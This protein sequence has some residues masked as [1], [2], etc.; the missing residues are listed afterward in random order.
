MYRVCKAFKFDALRQWGAGENNMNKQK[1]DAAPHCTEQQLVGNISEAQEIIEAFAFTD[2]GNTIG[3]VSCDLKTH[4]DYPHSW[5]VDA[6]KAWL[7]ANDSLHGRTPA[8]G[9]QHG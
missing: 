7:I 2:P 6:A 3:S 1:T 9:G 4:R 8:Q 5:A